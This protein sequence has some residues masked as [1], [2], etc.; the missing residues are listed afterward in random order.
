MFSLHVTTEEKNEEPSAARHFEI[1]AL[2]MVTSIFSDKLPPGY[3]IFFNSIPLV[4]KFF[5]ITQ[6]FKMFTKIPSST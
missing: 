4:F 5:N 1:R 6:V 3:D 2:I